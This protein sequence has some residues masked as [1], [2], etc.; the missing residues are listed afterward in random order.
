MIY[1]DE[2]A[3]HG[4]GL[5]AKRNIK[6]NEILGT[7]EGKKTKKNGPYVLWISED[8]G[9]EVKN[10]LRYIN[11]SAKPNAI[12]YDDLTVVAIRNI[13]KGEEITH[14]YGEEWK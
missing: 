7:V 5:F 4:K 12:Y 10:D 8:Q 3:I 9:F 11:H 13:K 2:S 14:N 6:K 1:V